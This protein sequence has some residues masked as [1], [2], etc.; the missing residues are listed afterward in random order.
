MA[1][2]D[3][4]HDAIESLREELAGVDARA[5]KLRQAI[6]ALQEILPPVALP[7][8]GKNQESHPTTGHR[9]RGV[10]MVKGAAIVLNEAHEPLHVNVIMER[11]I[12][13]GFKPGNPDSFRLSLVGS[14]DRGTKEQG[15][16]YKPAPATYGLREWQSNVG[17]TAN[18]NGQGVMTLDR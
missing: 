4:I 15:W 5:T 2:R 18:G 6:R 1:Q 3:S 7:T 9:L 11:M 10:T 12:Q 14:L 8:E 17:G 16:F 13:G